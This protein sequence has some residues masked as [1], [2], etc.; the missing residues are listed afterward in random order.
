MSGDDEYK[1]EIA[2]S[3][4]KDVLNS[5]EDI[6]NMVQCIIPIDPKDKKILEEGVDKLEIFK[7]KLEEATSLFELS[8][9]FD[10]DKLA[11][12]YDDTKAEINSTADYTSFCT[13]MDT[14]ENM[15]NGGDYGE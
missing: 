9:L 1:L 2:L 14:I 5:I 4:K 6:I 13:V 12:E 8:I 11:E 10:V 3:F 15:V 7:K